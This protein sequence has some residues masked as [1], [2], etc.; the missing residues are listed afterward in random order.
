MLRKI[1]ENLPKNRFSRKKI[2]HT[3]RSFRIIRRSIDCRTQTTDGH[4]LGTAQGIFSTKYHNYYR[5]QS[6]NLLL[7][8]ILSNRHNCHP[9]SHIV[10][11]PWVLVAKKVAPRSGGVRLPSEQRG[12][13]MD[14]EARD[15]EFTL[16][17]RLEWKLGMDA[18]LVTQAASAVTI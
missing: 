14:L 5:R 8:N 15:L 16:W 2:A 3:R 18:P 6:L 1:S 17:L 13:G 4:H 12:L 10:E 9:Q 11:V 7:P